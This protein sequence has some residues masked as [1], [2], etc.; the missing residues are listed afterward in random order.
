[1]AVKASTSPKADQPRVESK[2]LQRLD[3]PPS[4]TYRSQSNTKPAGR[5]SRDYIRR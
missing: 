1:M 4:L 5:D 2:Q 3:R